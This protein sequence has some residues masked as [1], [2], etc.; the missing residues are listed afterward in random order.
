MS[1]NY[2]L[3]TGNNPLALIEWFV[4]SIALIVVVTLVYIFVLNK[5]PP[6]EGITQ[7]KVESNLELAQQP[8]ATSLMLEAQTSLKAGNNVQTLDLS[9]KATVAMLN[10]ILAGM[11]VNS[12]NMNISDMAYLIQSKSLGSPDITQP[13]YQLNMLRLKSAQSQPISPQEAEW[14]LNIAIWLSQL[15]SSGK[16]VS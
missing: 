12:S 8:D 13:L 14:S 6:P 4:A 1:P 15:I 2:L 16:I 5:S 3:Q 10:T 11:G 9:V 7:A